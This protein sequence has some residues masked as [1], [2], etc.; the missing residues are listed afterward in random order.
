MRG[1]TRAS[2][3]AR[4]SALQREDLMQNRHEKDIRGNAP[5]SSGSRLR[6]YDPEE[7]TCSEGQIE[8]LLSKGESTERESEDEQRSV[9][10]ISRK[11]PARKT[12]A[13]NMSKHQQK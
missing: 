11:P 5:K 9:K 12:P 6:R 2:R 4:E 10:R 8:D 3:S 7:L 13:I 1:V